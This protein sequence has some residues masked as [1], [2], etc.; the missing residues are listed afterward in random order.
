[1][2]FDRY[3]TQFDQ[4]TYLV[5]G[6]PSSGFNCNAAATAML[7]Y[8]VTR[9]RVATS[10]CAVRRLMNDTVGG[11]NLEQSAAVLDH[12]GVTGYRLWRPGTYSQLVSL[13]Q[14]GLYGA[15]VQ[16]GYSAIAGTEYDCFE[17]QFRG[18]HSL[19]V[20]RM[21]ASSASEGDPGADG[22]RSVPDGWQDMPISLL[23][24]AAGRLPLND[25][26]LT[27]DTDFGT[28]HVYALIGP[29]D[30]LPVTSE[31]RVT[32]NAPAPASV[33]LYT[34]PFVKVVPTAG[35]SG[36]IHSSAYDCQ[37]TLVN[38]V[39]WF[40]IRDAGTNHGRFLTPSRYVSAVRA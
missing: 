7:L 6:K 10:A 36:R 31:W 40:Q 1:M 26:G 15:I 12:Y 29:R 30:P 27:L 18:G 14:T 33:Q 3:T 5:N 19:Y 37:R 23:G 25:A 17:G 38:G 39:W 16:V 35:D 8:R 11:T 24:R 20:A 9:G 13:L 28:G 22:R 32:I 4:C 34:R 21:T 2:T